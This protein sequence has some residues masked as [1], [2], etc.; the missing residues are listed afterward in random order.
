MAIKAVIAIKTIQ[1][2]CISRKTALGATFSNTNTRVLLKQ[3]TLLSTQ[4]LREK[5][6]K[7]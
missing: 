6:R 4:D 2:Y 5:K 7:S 1:G 3:T